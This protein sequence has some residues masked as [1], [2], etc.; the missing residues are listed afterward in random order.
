VIFANSADAG[1]SDTERTVLEHV[2]DSL[3]ES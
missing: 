1:D 3:A 2:T